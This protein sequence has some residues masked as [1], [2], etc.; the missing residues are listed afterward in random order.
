MK[1]YCACVLLF[2]LVAGCTV[3]EQIGTAVRD[4]IAAGVAAVDRNNDG[5]ITNRELQYSK[6]DPTFWIAI[7]SALLG[8]LGIGASRRAQKD[9]DELYD[10][11]HK[12]DAG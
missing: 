1:L 12:V 10:A 7:G 5:V 4:G 3:P 6:N 8:I 9:T 2:L 11:T